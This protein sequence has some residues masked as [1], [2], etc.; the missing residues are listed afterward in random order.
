MSFTESISTVLAKYS[1]FSGR[2]TRPEYWWFY[3]FTVLLSWGASIVGAVVF[4]SSSA[5]ASVLSL[6]I[7]FALLLPSLAVA[8]RRLHDTDRAGAWLLLSFTIIGII[9]VIIWL[10]TAGGAGP[11]RYGAPAAR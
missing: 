11:H 7:S 2:A 5:A 4:G 8:V 6:L 3:L 10:A 9:P 1:I